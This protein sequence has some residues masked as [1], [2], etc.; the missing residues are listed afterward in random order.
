MVKDTKMKLSQLKE[1]LLTNYMTPNL[2]KSFNRTDV[3]IVIQKWVLATLLF[4]HVLEVATT[5][6]KAH[7]NALQESGAHPLRS[8]CWHFTHV[9]LDAETQ[10]LYIG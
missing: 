5:T 4:A 1:N 9:L 3:T 10:L 6:L 2:W 7:L 8:I